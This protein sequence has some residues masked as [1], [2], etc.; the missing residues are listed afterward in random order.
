M[1]ITIR[2]FDFREGN[3]GQNPN[4]IAMLD[5]LTNQLKVFELRSPFIRPSVIELGHP[6]LGASPRM[7]RFQILNWKS[8]KSEREWEIFT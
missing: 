6:R 3:D 8:I 2:L 1:S 4:L 7:T 5:L